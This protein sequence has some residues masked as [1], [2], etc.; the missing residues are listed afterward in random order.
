MRSTPAAF[1]EVSGVGFVMAAV[2]SVWRPDAFPAAIVDGCAV[3]DAASRLEVR[4]NLAKIFLRQRAQT[5]W[6]F[7]EQYDRE[8][9]PTDNVR[10]R[11]SRL[12]PA[13]PA[14]LVKTARAS[15]RHQFLHRIAT[16]SA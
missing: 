7:L 8:A 16:A 10:G 1:G 13:S 4:A 3:L 14:L 12:N 15:V 5:G 9:P 6:F 11:S 2:L